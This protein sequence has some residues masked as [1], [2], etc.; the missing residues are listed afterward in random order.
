MVLGVHM[1]PVQSLAV[2]EFKKGVVNAAT[3]LLQTVVNLALV[4]HQRREAATPRN[5]QVMF[6]PLRYTNKYI[7]F[8]RHQLNNLKTCK[9]KEYL[10]SVVKTYA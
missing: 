8:Y 6:I 10:M 1:N 9:M 2:E 5:V 3:L 7:N 4:H